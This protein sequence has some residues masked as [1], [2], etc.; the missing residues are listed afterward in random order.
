MA[1]RSKRNG[2]R[3]ASAGASA[4]T[5]GNKKSALEFSDEEG[6][7]EEESPLST[8][9]GVR[10]A[11]ASRTPLRNPRGGTRK[12]SHVDDDDDEDEEDDESQ[13]RSYAQDDLDDSEVGYDDEEEDHHNAR[14][15]KLT[16]MQHPS[17]PYSAGSYLPTA[18]GGA[19]GGPEMALMGSASQRDRSV[20]RI[21]ARSRDTRRDISKERRVRDRSRSQS[22]SRQSRNQTQ[23]ENQKA[24]DRAAE[25]RRSRRAS[26]EMSLGMMGMEDTS[27]QG[28]VYSTVSN[29][30]S[31]ISL[32]SGMDSSFSHNL[33]SAA[34]SA[35]ATKRSQRAGPGK[36]MSASLRDSTSTDST[37]ERRRQVY[38][39]GRPSKT[40]DGRLDHIL[41][42]RRAGSS[43]DGGDG[44]GTASE[45]ASHARSL[46]P[47]TG[48][49]K[50]KRGGRRKNTPAR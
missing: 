5:N 26:L 29:Q 43:S 37:S 45:S 31:A 6:S 34:N 33:D 4:N 44:L 25:R 18:Y 2:G 12:S 24:S 1:S 15:R 20:D 50:D 9:R 8:T 14:G 49:G 10:A 46:S 30:Q 13:R 28:S 19:P 21:R 35:T 39:S 27:D 42:R 17:L 40:W 16:G 11:P 41:N 3:N 23:T 38:K 22:Q 48:A 36:S 7:E 47:S 32:I